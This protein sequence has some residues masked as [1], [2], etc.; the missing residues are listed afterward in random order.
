MCNPANN[1]D[2]EMLFE[3]MYTLIDI[4]SKSNMLHDRKNI[5]ENIEKTIKQN[6]YKNER[7]ASD[8]YYKKISRKRDLGGKYDTRAFGIVPEDDT[9]EF[10]DGDV[11]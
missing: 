5:L 8:F 10:E 7:D 4:E 3:M 1:N 6:F 9:E 2:E 11:E